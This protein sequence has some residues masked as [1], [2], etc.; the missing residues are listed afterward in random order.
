MIKNN[1]NADDKLTIVGPEP[2]RFENKKHQRKVNIEA[3]LLMAKYDKDFKKKIFADRDKAIKESGIGFSEEEIKL[4]KSLNDSTL[5][6]HIDNFEV[7]GVT[8]SSLKSWATAASVILLLSS[9]FVR[10]GDS[11]DSSNPSGAEPLGNTADREYVEERSNL[12]E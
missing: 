10:C 12:N 9:I 1:Y 5:K 2:S 6:L 8:K 4:L 3:L 11:D 7:K